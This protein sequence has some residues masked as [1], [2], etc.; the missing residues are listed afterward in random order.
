LRDDQWLSAVRSMREFPALLEDS[1]QTRQTVH[2]A[3]E[4]IGGSALLS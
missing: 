2:N 4:R 3:F 1:V